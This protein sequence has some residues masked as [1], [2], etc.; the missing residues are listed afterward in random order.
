MKYSARVSLAS[1]GA[2][3]LLVMSYA[4]S[5]V[6]APDLVIQKSDTDLKFVSCELGEPLVEGTIVIR[7]SGDTDANL[8]EASDFFRSFVAVYNPENIDLIEKDTKRTK[9]EPKEQRSISISVGRGKVKKGRSYNAYAVTSTT[10][11][12]SD[13]EWLT[14]RD[15]YENEIKEVQQFLKNRGYSIPK[16]DGVW[17]S[18]SKKALRN[19]QDQVGL[20]GKGEW[21]EAT[22]QKITELSGKGG[23]SSSTIVNEKD[24]QGRTK[25]TVFAVVD[26]YNLIEE[27]NENN[28]I[29][30]LIGYVPDCD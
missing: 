20:A 17:G 9:M 8:R 6:A 4:A 21:N 16:I 27:S 28:N 10:G 12:P 22:A 29:L 3:A 25:I 2:T 5:A 1:A 18:G 26:P 7:N 19:F 15:K 23:S 11:Y 13:P 14:N 24:K 30:P